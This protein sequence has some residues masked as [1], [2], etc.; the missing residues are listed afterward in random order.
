M[1]FC[2]TN[3]SLIYHFSLAVDSTKNVDSKKNN[4]NYKFEEIFAIDNLKEF[5]QLKSGPTYQDN[6]GTDT[7]IRIKTN[8]N[9]YVVLNAD[10]NKRWDDLSLKLYKILNSEFRPK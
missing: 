3:D 7:E 5:S 8:K 4:T 9:E 1:I 6:D 10:R 2:I